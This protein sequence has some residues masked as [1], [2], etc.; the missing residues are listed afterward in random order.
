MIALLI[1]FIASIITIFITF[2]NIKDCDTNYGEIIEWG[3]QND[4]QS[5]YD[6]NNYSNFDTINMQ[7]SPNKYLKYTI[8][9][10]TTTLNINESGNLEIIR[11]MYPD[12]E[13]YIFTFC[14]SKLNG[15]SRRTKI[16]E[17]FFYKLAKII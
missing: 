10:T 3:Y 9:N 8:N 6:F 15:I 2:Y 1:S 13:E 11:D 17:M 5:N 4:T 7:D 14:N 12:G 16:N